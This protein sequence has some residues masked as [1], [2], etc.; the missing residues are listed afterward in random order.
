MLKNID[1]IRNLLTDKTVT[2]WTLMLMTKYF[3]L[4]RWNKQN[5]DR[6]YS[7][8]KRRIMIMSV[9]D[10]YRLVLLYNFINY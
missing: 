9:T 2:L 4:I 10:D 8:A 1:F 5:I 7:V 3:K 6:K